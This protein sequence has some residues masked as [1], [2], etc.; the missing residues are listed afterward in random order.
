[1][2]FLVPHA[3]PDFDR[4]SNKVHF[5]LLTAGGRKFVERWKDEEDWLVGWL[6]W[7][8]EEQP[9]VQTRTKD[10]HNSIR[11]NRCTNWKTT[12][13][14][15]LLP[16]TNRI[17]TKAHRHQED[18]TILSSLFTLQQNKDRLL[19]LYQPRLPSLLNIIHQNII[20]CH[21]TIHKCPG[22]LLFI[23]LLV[24]RNIQNLFENMTQNRSSPCL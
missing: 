10:H 12:R 24:Y 5:L 20:S 11:I 14:F 3:L 15:L 16:T 4:E 19:L 9:H 1:M 23:Y 6:V 7:N 17:K 21:Y 18:K 2:R 22:R 8:D 13:H